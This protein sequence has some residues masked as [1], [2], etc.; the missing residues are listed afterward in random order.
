MCVLAS[1]KSIGTFVFNLRHSGEK[2]KFIPSLIYAL[3][4]LATLFEAIFSI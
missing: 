4:S 3:H 1:G 2:E